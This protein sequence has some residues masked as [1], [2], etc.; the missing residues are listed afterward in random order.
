VSALML[1]VI[2]AALVCGVQAIRAPRLLNATLWLAAVSA[3]TSILLYA[4]GAP[5][6]AVIELSVGA[7]LVT[8][9]FVFA[10]GISG[11]SAQEARPLVPKPLAL[12]LV[13]AC[14]VLLGIMLAPMVQHAVRPE[15]SFAVALWQGR[16]LDV[17]AQMVLIF[18]GALGVRGLLAESDVP[19]TIADFRLR[20]ARKAEVK[21]AQAQA[22][23]EDTLV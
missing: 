7:G 4:M 10:I 1:A 18:T 19:I 6:L 11:E 20:M 21:E 14:L 23:G 16:A 8:V 13:G 17:L 15:A 22:A 9:L 12:G 2:G 5:E 3:D